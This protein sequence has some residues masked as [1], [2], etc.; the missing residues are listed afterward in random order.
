M[1]SYVRANL[2]YSDMIQRASGAGNLI[3]LVVGYN[4]YWDPMDWKLIRHCFVTASRSVSV[5]LF[6]FSRDMPAINL[7]KLL[8]FEA[9]SPATSLEVGEY[10][11]TQETYRKVYKPAWPL[12]IRHRGIHSSILAFNTPTFSSWPP[13][14][15]IPPSIQSSAG[16]IPARFST[17]SPSRRCRPSTPSNSPYSSSRSS[18]FKVAPSPSTCRSR[19]D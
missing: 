13:N 6:C 15:I 4:G 7:A 3:S 1:F 19:M 12:R 2:A 16:K 17:V 18:R 5:L 14:L 10:K 8:C 11:N 9:A